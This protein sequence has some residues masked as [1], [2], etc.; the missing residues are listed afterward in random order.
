M[1]PRKTTTAAKVAAPR[2]AADPRI[3]TGERRDIDATDANTMPTDAVGAQLPN[4]DVRLDANDGP[5][6]A[7]AA[8]SPAPATDAAVALDDVDARDVDEYAGYDAD[9]S[10]RPGMG[11]LVAHRHFD[12]TVGAGGSEVTRY[13]HVVD[14]VTDTDDRT[15]ESVERAVVAWLSTDV[16]HPIVVDDLEKV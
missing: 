10:G 14:V 16:S 1:P 11:D 3:T 2:K 6:P 9:S 5:A 8:P 15:G 12:H 13:G 4:P 7:P